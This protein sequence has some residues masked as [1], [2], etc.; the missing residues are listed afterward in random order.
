[1]NATNHRPLYAVVG[2][3]ICVLLVSALLVSAQST[4]PSIPIGENQSSSLASAS[5]TMQFGVAVTTPQNVN[6]E[7]LATSAGFTP[8][9]RV[10]DPNNAI[11]FDDANAEAQN[12]IQDQVTLASPGTYVVEVRSAN[13][14]AGQFTISIQPGAPFTA[15]IPLP[16]QQL[17][18]A[19]VDPQNTRQV[20]SFTALSTDALFVEAASTLPTSARSFGWSMA[21][22]ATLLDSPTPL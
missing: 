15:P 7:I 13:S 14:S 18:T 6:V 3:L 16:M 4:P 5:S 21:T 19:T 22:P 11:I 17:I 12:I 1:M 20:F 10:I 8:A 9:F 2:A